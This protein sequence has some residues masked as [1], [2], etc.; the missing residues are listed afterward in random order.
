MT[1][2]KPEYLSLLWGIPALGLFFYW[3]FRRQRRRLERFA[4]PVMAAKLKLEF[5][6]RRATGK[7]VCLIGFFLFGLLAAARPQWGTKLE[8]V[9]RRGIDIVL[10]IDT[11]FSM[12]TEDVAPDRFEKARG[13]IRRLIILSAGDRMGLVAFSGAAAVQCPLTLDRSA[14]ELFLDSAATGMIP[15]PG[16]SLGA[17]IESATT[18][19]VSQETKYKVLVLFTD[20][21]DLAGQVDDAIAKAKEAGVI[22]YTVGIGTPQGMPVPIRDKEGAVVEYR[23][24][25]EGKV[26]ISSLDERSL[27]EI[28]SRTAGRYFRAT[29]SEGEIDRLY[30]DI[31]RLEKK[32]LESQLFHNYEDRFQYPLALAVVFLIA[33]SWIGEK[34]RA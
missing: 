23:K 1:F 6:R 5:G 21:E 4:G 19:F 12:N 11:S 26:V 20:G 18:A 10:A 15:Q 14:V 34:R 17:A 27:A 31:S 9:H 3:S 24:D 13:E 8:T 16:T 28:A 2:A 22:I 25:P 29:A 32:A 33:A 30:D 7:A